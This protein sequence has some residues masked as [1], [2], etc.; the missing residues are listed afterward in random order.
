MEQCTSYDWQAKATKLSANCLQVLSGQ[1]LGLLLNH[2]EHGKYSQATP[3]LMNACN[4]EEAEVP[5]SFLYLLGLEN[6]FN[7]TENGFVHLL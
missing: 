5:Y 2:S 7:A 1:L 3:G 6:Q 4:C